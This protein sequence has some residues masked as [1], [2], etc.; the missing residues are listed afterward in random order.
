LQADLGK[1]RAF[2][3]RQIKQFPTF[4]HLQILMPHA[5]TSRYAIAPSAHAVPYT[6]DAVFETRF[7]AL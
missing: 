7:S 6:L 4:W 1:G 3:D 2:A 5:A